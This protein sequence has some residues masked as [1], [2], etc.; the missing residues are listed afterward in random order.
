MSLHAPILAAIV[1]ENDMSDDIDFRESLY[2]VARSGPERPGVYMF[3]DD[4]GKILYIGKAKN[5]RRRLLDYFYGKGHAFQVPAMLARARHLEFTVTA[6]EREALILEASMI[7]YYKPRYN[8]LLKDDKR[9][10]YLELT[11]EEYPRL[12][13][14]RR[15][16]KDGGKYFGPFTSGPIRKTQRMLTKMFRLRSCSKMRPQGCVYGDIGACMAPCRGDCSREEYAEAVSRAELFLSGKHK[17][18]MNIIEENMHRAASSLNFEEAAVLRDQ[19]KAVSRLS[20]TQRVDFMG[21]VTLDALTATA[22]GPNKALVML[23]VVRDGLVVARK[24][25]VLGMPVGSDTGDILYA[26]ILQYYN[27]ASPPG[28]ILLDEELDDMEAIADWLSSLRGSTVRISVP[29]AG[30]RRKLM[31]LVKENLHLTVSIM[32]AEDIPQPEYNEGAKQLMDELGL[33]SIPITIECFDISTIQGSYSVGSKVLLRSGWPDKRQYRRYRI[34]TVGG[35]DDFAM[36]YEVI[37]RRLSHL[38]TEPLPDLMLIDGGKGQLA[39]AL[40]AARDAGID[41]Q[42]LALA[43]KEEECYLPGK[44]QPV[45]LPDNSPALSILVRARDEAHRFA[46]SYHRNLRGRGQLESELDGVPGLGRK[47]KSALLR[48]FGSVKGI[49][50]ASI[51]QIMDVKGIGREMARRIKDHIG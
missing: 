21:D 37:K 6:T 27:S 47:R 12:V 45:K 30:S 24:N 20:S 28:E 13:V 34:K 2:D 14:V 44:S 18:L 40:R 36:M 25:F 38:D 17:E 26:F 16:K 49:R 46:I 5:I 11:P 9:F 42:F 1:G 19:L 39:A 43:K 35:Q 8:I 22:V 51:E 31:E 3:K 32:M 7:R 23:Y 50:K 48:R 4:S 10:P 15:I 41:I 33:Q 29:T